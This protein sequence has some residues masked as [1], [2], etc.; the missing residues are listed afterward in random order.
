MP[1]DLLCLFSPRLRPPWIFNNISRLS[2][3][4]HTICTRPEY[5]SISDSHSS[6]PESSLMAMIDFLFNEQSQP[7]TRRF[8]IQF[9]ALL[10]SNTKFSDKLIDEFFGMYRNRLYHLIEPL[11]PSLDEQEK[12]H[13][14]IMVV[15]LMEGLLIMLGSGVHQQT[16]LHGIEDSVK[17]QILNIV[18]S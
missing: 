10:T 6:N 4:C 1:M 15:S 2:E 5:F 11:N 7:Q 12:K 13:R 8:Y 14:T 16:D 18:R 17:K 3:T 9:W